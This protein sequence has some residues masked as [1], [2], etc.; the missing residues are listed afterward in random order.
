MGKTHKLLI[1]GAVVI[2]LNSAYLASFADPTLA[3]VLNVLLH[4]G[5]GFLFVTLLVWFHASGGRWGALAL[6][7]LTGGL[8]LYLAI[9]AATRD[10]RWVLWG[11]IASGVLLLLLLAATFASKKL[12][13]KNYATLLAA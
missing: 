9:F 8:G 5:V 13:W 12:A 4:V 6:A 7:V 3:Y 1:I 10:H 2:A 11:H